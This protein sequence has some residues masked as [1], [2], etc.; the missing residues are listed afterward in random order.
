MTTY[1]TEIHGPA[2]TAPT[3]TGYV[4]KCNLCGVTWQV[5]GPSPEFTDAQSCDFCGCSEVTILYE[6]GNYPETIVMG[7]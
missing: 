5:Q 6:D 7:L 4:A 3:T 2:A 1:S